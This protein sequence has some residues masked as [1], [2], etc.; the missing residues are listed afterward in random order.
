MGGGGDYYGR[1]VTDKRYRSAS[2]ASNMAERELSRASIDTSFLPK[3]RRL[4]CNA[5]NPLVYAFDETGSMDKLPKIIYDKW[6]GIVG[7]IVARKYLSDPQMSLAAIGDITSDTA[8]IQIAPF[9]ALRNLDRYFRN[10][11]F[12]GNGG[13]QSQESYEMMAYYY[14][15][16]CDIPKAENPIFL[17][18]GDEGF[19]EKL[20]AYDLFEHFGGEHKETTAKK[21]FDDLLKKFKGNAFLIHR[22]YPGGKDPSIVRQWEGALGKER[23]IRM[24]EGE[25]GDLAIGDITLGVYAIVSG[26][27]TLEQYLEDMRTRPLDLGTDI[28]YE[29]QTPARIRDVAKALKPLENFRPVKAPRRTAKSANGKTSSE[30]KPPAKKKGKGNFRF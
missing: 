3:N 29:P 30:K 20:F 24:P 2:G 4:E 26:G 17:F 21:V 19:R 9:S 18:T 7:Q 27:R 14:A 28:E 5:L 22:Y 6:P 1:D 12:E 25:S 10:I 23:I 15:Y 8:P 16:L 13:G 11:Y